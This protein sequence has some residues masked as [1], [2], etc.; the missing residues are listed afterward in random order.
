MKKLAAA[1]A[2]LC[3]VCLSGCNLENEESSHVYTQQQS[4]TP[5][6]FSTR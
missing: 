1:L 6:G 5:P 3:A 2:L 4:E